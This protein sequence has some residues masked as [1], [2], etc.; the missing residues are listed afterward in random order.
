MRRFAAALPFAL[1]AFG[2]ARAQTVVVREP[3]PGP[4][5]HELARVL[6][7][8]HR[9]Y[10]PTPDSG[11][12]VLHR[13]STFTTNVVVIGRSAALDGRVRGDIYVVDGD[14]FLRPGAQVEG[15]A[16]AIGGGVYTSM[17]DV[18][19]R[20]TESHRDFT[21]DLVPD[22]AGFALVFR[23][24]YGYPSSFFDLPGLYGFRI[25][26]YDRVNG[27]SLPLAP[28]LSLLASRLTI[29]PGLTWRTH[30]G[31]I[32]PGLRASYRPVRRDRFVATVERAT[33]S[34]DDWIFDDLVNSASVLLAGYDTR[35]H[36]RADR[37][38]LTAHRLFESRTAMIE[39]F[40][41]GR[42]ERAW[43][44]GPDSNET[45]HPWS[46]FNQSDR[47]RM[48]R[49]NPL[50]DDGHIASV[51]VGAEFDWRLDDM[52]L[53]FDLF[54]EGA[55][56]SPRA[57]QFA[58]A[59]LGG[60]VIFPTFGTQWMKVETHLVFGSNGTP[61]QRWAYLGGLGT[62]PI[63]DPLEMGGDQLVYLQSTYNFPIEQIVIPYAGVPTVAMRHIIGSAGVGRLP[64]FEQ[65][66]GL[67]LVASFVRLQFDID[68]AT[69]DSLF[70]VAL[71]IIR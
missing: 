69:G 2:T 20:G 16:I 67:A 21:F 6:E 51:L 71:A 13:D 66:L 30:L 3:G 11:R 31:A 45:G 49:P 52:R 5:G 57:D 1:A 15:R 59:T 55:F 7:A 40:L 68:P 29:D 22:G 36:F 43:S 32:D 37:G 14:L 60:D 62:L 33:Y 27:L 61:S 17:L 50:I 24:L 26:A 10:L 19:R 44:A 53:E 58:Q 18:A 48:L 47:D 54:G 23:S 8:P 25:P 34:N 63:L 65:D 64:P 41:G 9:L 12:L 28:R 39:P 38:D 56:T 46:L 4:M 35:N 42:W 70:G